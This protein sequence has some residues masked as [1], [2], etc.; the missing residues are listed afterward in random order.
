MAEYVVYGKIIIDDIALLGG[1]AVRS[2]LGGGGPQAAFGARLW[3]DS[4]GLV[5]RTGADLDSAQ[6]E[7]LRALDVDLAGW[8]RF[9]VI[10]H[11]A[12][13]CN[14]TP[15]SISPAAD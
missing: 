7:T 10:P 4:V 5:T 15:R 8:F 13:G 2:M 3:S 1:G 11:R 12:I 14:T 9:P 6:V